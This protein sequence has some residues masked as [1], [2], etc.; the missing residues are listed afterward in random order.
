MKIT[1]LVFMVFFV[2]FVMAS[3]AFA[4]EKYPCAGDVAKFCGN[5][6]PGEGRQAL[7]LK[8][9]QAQL[10]PA[11]KMHLVK[12][13]EA[14]KETRQACENDITKYC[15]GVQPGEGRIAKC[16]RANKSHLSQKCRMKIIE[17]K[18]EIME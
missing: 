16:L 3:G 7:C 4:Q 5:V 9:H 8:E 10:S 14:L 2:M 13:E 11:C 1:S 17:E 6:R 12:G 15:K 18:K